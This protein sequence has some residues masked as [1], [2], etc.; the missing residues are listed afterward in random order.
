MFEKEQDMSAENKTSRLGAVY[1]AESSEEVSRVYDAWAEK[2]DEDMSLAG[3]RHPAVSWPFYPGM[4]PAAQSPC[5]MRAPG[6]A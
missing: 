5:W 1:N 4:F 6:Q 3:Y 2:Y